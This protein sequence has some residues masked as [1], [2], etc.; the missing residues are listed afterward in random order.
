[1][2]GQGIQGIWEVSIAVP[3]F[4]RTVTDRV[5]L[6]FFAGKCQVLGFARPLFRCH[7]TISLLFGQHRCNLGQ[8]LLTAIPDD[9]GVCLSQCPAY[10]N[11]GQHVFAG[12]GE[13][14]Y[15]SVELHGDNPFPTMLRPAWQQCE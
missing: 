2:V 9:D 7:T 12:H 6:R 4:L 3:R 11:R 14:F 1:M 5:A 8:E 10:G 15:F 13:R